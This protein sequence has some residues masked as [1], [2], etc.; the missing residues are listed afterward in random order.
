MKRKKIFFIAGTIISIAVLVFAYYTISPLFINIKLDNQN[1]SASDFQN[2]SVAVVGSAGHSASGKVRVVTAD[3]KTYVRYENFKTVNGPDLYV[4]LAKDL[5]SKE[6]ADLGKV[7]A[8]EGN[9]NYEVPAN[10][11]VSDYR[12]VITWC[13]PFGV[14]FNYADISNLN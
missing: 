12:Y 6:F 10:V 2:K 14:L 4:Y 13:K 3:G 7:K 1:P 11:N 5:D 9:I 8:T